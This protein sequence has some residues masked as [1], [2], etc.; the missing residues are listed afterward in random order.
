M[1]DV[2]RIGDRFGDYSVRALLGVGGSAEVYLAEDAVREEL[3]ALKVAVAGD[4]EVRRRFRNEIV[5]A[6]GLRHPNIAPIYG[7]GEWEAMLWLAYPYFPGGCAGELVARPSGG[8]EIARVLR[9]L[10][11]VADALDYL[12]GLE[13]VHLDV[14]PTNMLV[15]EG[16]S[17][18]LTDFGIARGWTGPRSRAPVGVGSLPYAAPEVLAGAAPTPAADQY[19]LACSAIEFLTGHPPFPLPSR[20]AVLTAHLR[21]APP[22]VSWR[23]PWIPHAVDSIL[24][25]SLAKRPEARYASCAEPIRLI[26][27]ALRD[28]DPPRLRP[29]R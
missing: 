10:A 18:V 22:D 9:V 20:R 3:V 29:N 7:H 12:H 25:K 21:S 6:G 8:I 5:I 14:K 26:T 28:A 11:G 23:R 13:L 1:S 2:L 24:A 16:D 4:D 17:G 27:R 15:G 19:S